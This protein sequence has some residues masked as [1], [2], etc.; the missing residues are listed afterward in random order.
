M[1]EP[2]GQ[3]I[4]DAIRKKGIT[5]EDFASEMGMSHRNLANLLNKNHIPIDQLVRVSKLLNQDFI[6]DYTDWLYENESVLKPYKLQ[7]VSKNQAT[8]DES[9]YASI[10]VEQI[11]F[12][13]KVQGTFEAVTSEMASFI[14]SVKKE[15]EER[16]LHLV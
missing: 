13:F 16:G 11:S 1:K 2:I 4:R 7:T 10:P 14:Q 8:D 15:A 9:I 6:K 5:Q 12:S 3:L